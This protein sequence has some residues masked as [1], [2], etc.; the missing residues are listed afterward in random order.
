MGVNASKIPCT[1]RKCTST[2]LE[3]A[4]ER[5][6]TMRAKFVRNVQENAQSERTRK[7]SEDA[8]KKQREKA[9]K[10]SLA[11]QAKC[12]RKHSWRT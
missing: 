10:N 7:P 1:H 6:V 5:A 12:S 3:I 2:L 9:W 4:E 8:V 11:T